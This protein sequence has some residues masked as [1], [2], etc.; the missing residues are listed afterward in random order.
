[1]RLGNEVLFGNHMDLIHGKRVGLLT[2]PTGVDAHL[3][4]TADRL[5]AAEGVT[6]AALYGPEHGIW[7]SAPDG[8]PVAASHD[9]RYGVAAYSLYG[10]TRRP[11]AQMLEGIDVMLVDIQDVGVRFYTFIYTM[12]YTMAACGAHDVP[13][14][15]LDRP[16]PIGGDVLEGNCLS[17]AFSSFVG[18]Y[19]ILLRHGMTVGELAGLFNAEYGLGASLTVVP[20]EGW[21]RDMRFADTGLFWVPPSP[22]MPTPDTATVYPG[23]CLFEGT[24]VSEGRGTARPFEQIGAPYVD[25][26]TLAGDL[27]AL[28]LPGVIFRPT[29]FIPI[30]S[31]FR[32]QVCGG[33]QVHVTDP[34]TFRPARAGLEM[35]SAIRQRYPDAFAWREPAAGSSYFFDKLAGTDA[36]RKAIVRG[37]PA[38]EIAAGWQDDI[39]AFEVFRKPYLIY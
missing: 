25:A 33:V 27:N 2:N 35:V 18:A 23:T 36:V 15:V 37:I 20:M 11:T 14:A 21:R 31:K 4:H 12:A 10:E 38:G 17:P 19:P 16:N 30:S 8:A 13:V 1:M 3:L 6:L 28:G 34:A 9:D 5:H 26:R 22:N 24:N 39:E 29:S 7:G 32:D